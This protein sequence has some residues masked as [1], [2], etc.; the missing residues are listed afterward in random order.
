MPSFTA[1]VPH[2][3]GREA[4]AG[5]LKGFAD[6][7]RDR[8]KDLVKNVEESWGDDGTLNFSFKTMGLTIG[9]TIE[10]GDDAVKLDGTLPF[11]AIAFKGKIEQ[12]IRSQLEKAL[13]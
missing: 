4:A 8:Y 11:A 5:R 10:I 13:R 3:M 9:G 12:E 2:G 6:K 7:I 1:E